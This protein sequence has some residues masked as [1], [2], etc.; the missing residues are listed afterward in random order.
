M[1][2][3]SEIIEDTKDGNMPTHE[4]CYWAMLC[5][6]WLLNNDHRRLQEELL[7]ENQAPEFIRKMKADNSHNAYNTALNKSPKDYLGPNN[8]PSN[9]EYQRFRKFG[10]KIVDKFIKLSE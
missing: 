3:L 7:A 10:N 2:T 5:F 6:N 9:P 8:D 1:R 4:E